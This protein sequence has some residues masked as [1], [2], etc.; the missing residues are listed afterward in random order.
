M[1]VCDFIKQAVDIDI[2]SPTK[3]YYTTRYPFKDIQIIND[4]VD[5]LNR[6]MDKG[7][8]A[9]I[10]SAIKLVCEDP[11]KKKILESMA[12]SY[13]VFGESYFSSVIKN[14]VDYLSGQKNQIYMQE[15]TNLKNDL[16]MKYCVTGVL[17]KSIVEKI[18]I[19]CYEI[20]VYS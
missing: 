14:S 5:C 11:T 9:N 17:N 13:E 12:Y 2:V 8:K 1:N 19:L 16:Y 7:N 15:I 18:M 3:F 10:L 20:L 6:D 4:I